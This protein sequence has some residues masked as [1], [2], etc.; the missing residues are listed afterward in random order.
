M[1]S[2]AR[3]WMVCEGVMVIGKV[4]PMP[5][6]LE[7][8]FGIF[9]SPELKTKMKILDAVD[10]SLDQISIAEICRNAGVSR[11][12][13][14]R[15]FNSKY[16]IPCWHSIYCRQ[17]YLNEIGR[18]VDWNTGYYHHLRLIDQKRSFYRKSIQYSINSPFGHTVMPANREAVLLETLEKYRGIS[19]DANMRFIVTTFS[20][21]ECEVLNEWFR[22]DESTDLIRWTEDLVSLV[23]HRLY[24][25][26]DIEGT[27][28]S[29]VSPTSMA[30]LE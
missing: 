13:F 14:Y 15:H 21:L 23:P 6:N 18:T 22:S 2:W 3:A 20:K 11:Q 9:E 27:L 4:V 1:V 5:Q 26:L 17:F 10:K 29:S 25:A 8:G 19:P 7:T 16:D 12:T 24:E 30:I 28:Q